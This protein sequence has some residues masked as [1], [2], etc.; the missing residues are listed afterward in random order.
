MTRPADDSR[1]SAPRNAPGI[2]RGCAWIAVGG[3]FAGSGFFVAPGWVVTSAHV[4][5]NTDE[6]IGVAV[7]PDGIAPTR[8]PEPLYRARLG[9]CHPESR[10]GGPTYAFPDLALLRAPDAPADVPC[11]QLAAQDPVPGDWLLAA[12]WSPS[13]PTSGV[14]RDT[15]RFAVAG[16]AA[17]YLR[18]QHDEIRDG[19]SGSP[20]FDEAGL[21][22]GIVKATRDRKSIRGGWIT[23]VS[24]LRR[25][26]AAEL[27]SAL[28]GVWD[29]P[30]TAVATGDAAAPPILIPIRELVEALRAVPRMDDPEFRALLLTMVGDELGE[31][32]GMQVPFS[33]V[34]V[35]HMMSI[36]KAYR[37]HETP[38][39]FLEALCLAVDLTRGGTAGAAGLRRLVSENTVG[40]TADNNGADG[41]RSSRGTA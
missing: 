18:V 23:P 40:G 35:E 20:A 12:G 5:H 37:E 13:T 22:R 25:V 34:P 24:A 2:R 14:Q 26:L 19:L 6:P 41:A 27:P 17:E 36:A 15:L 39:A 21:L 16:D 32:V 3:R 10:G 9:S 8:P 28:R 30:K 1:A 7:H 31:P 38:Y 4:V 29:L 33:P 11:V